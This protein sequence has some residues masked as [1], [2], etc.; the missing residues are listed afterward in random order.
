VDKYPDTP[1]VEIEILG[2]PH[3]RH[4]GEYLVCRVECTLTTPTATTANANLIA[5]APEMLEALEGVCGANEGLCFCLDTKG[6]GLGQCV[7]CD[8]RAAIA[9]AK[10]V[11]P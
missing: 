7:W 8:V 11:T 5:A 3:Y 2:H 10:G 6:R 9:K 4:G 1:G